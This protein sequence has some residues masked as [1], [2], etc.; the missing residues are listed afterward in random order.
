MK[1]NDQLLSRFVRILLAVCV[2]AAFFVLSASDALAAAGTGLEIQSGSRTYAVG[3]KSLRSLKKSGADKEFEKMLTAAIEYRYGG[4]PDLPE[5]VD[6]DEYDS[7]WEAE[8]ALMKQFENAEF[9]DEELKALADSYLAG[10]RMLCATEQFEAGDESRLAMKE[11]L[12]AYMAYFSA[13]EELSDRFGLE[14]SSLDEESVDMVNTAFDILMETTDLEP[15]GDGGD[16]DNNDDLVVID[17]PDPPEPDYPTVTDGNFVGVVLDDGTVRITNYTARDY[18]C[19]PIPAEIDGHTVTEIGAEAFSY[20]SFEDLVIPETVRE[21]QSRAFDY[22]HISGS[23]VL[24]ENILIGN[25]A[26]EYAELPEKVTL[27]QG[28]HV[29][30]QAFSYCEGLKVLVLENDVTLDKRAFEYAEELQELYLS[31]GNTIGESAFGY[32][33]TLVM[34]GANEN[35]QGDADIVIDERAFEYCDNLMDTTFID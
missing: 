5:D 26:F 2:S 7:V 24:P 34:I 11:L 27:P 35:A 22:T 16:D 28:A 20:E 12:A 6:L 1:K 19:L 13:L 33:E 10:L 8:Y 18:P 4:S 17:G 23:L 21:I 9:R 30:L 25:C 15:G 29:S 32:V 3:R 14:L 31:P